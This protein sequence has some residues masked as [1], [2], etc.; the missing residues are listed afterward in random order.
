MRLK[1][2]G[3]LT[4]LAVAVTC[5]CRPSVLALNTSVCWPGR[6]SCR[7]IMIGAVRE[8][9]AGASPRRGKRHADA[10]HHVAERIGHRRHQRDCRKPVLTVAF[11]PDPD[12]T[13]ILSPRGGVGQA[14][15]GRHAHAAGRRLKRYSCPPI[16]FA[17]NSLGHLAG[18]VRRAV[19]GDAAVR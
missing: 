15:T 4:P 11:W 13:A 19:D 12:A 16:V 8:R 18:A 1:F 10:G 17:V 6:S 14:E 3:V 5:S 9:A 7:S 2:A